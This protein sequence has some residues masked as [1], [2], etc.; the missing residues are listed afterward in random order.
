LPKGWVALTSHQGDAIFELCLFLYSKELV[1]A[2]V[3]V[4][5]S[6][7]QLNDLWL[8]DVERRSW[9]IPICGGAPPA[10]RE[11]HC[12]TTIKHY[13]VVAGGVDGSQRFHDIHVLDTN[14]MVRLDM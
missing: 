6:G 13:L 9:T 2:D 4:G 12:C 1:G 8:Y 11:M 5:R 7:C 3:V 14:R 10:P